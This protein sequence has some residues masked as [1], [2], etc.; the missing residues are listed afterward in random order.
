[1]G[2]AQKSLETN[3]RFSRP[4]ALRLDD[5]IRRIVSRIIGLFVLMFCA[6]SS[7]GS[8]VDVFVVDK[9][10]RPVADVAVYAMR[11]DEQYILPAPTAG[12]IM[13]QI[14]M[15]FVP[16]LLVVQTATSVEFPNNDTVAHHVYS[17]SYLNKFMLSMY[18]GKQH[19][20]VTFEHS[21]VVTLGCNI[22]DHMLGYIL[23][24]DST[25]FTKTD[26]NGK[27]LLSLDNP[28]DYEISIWSPR[29]R[30]GDELL[31]KTVVMPGNP[32]SEVKFQLAKKLNPP[33]GGQ[34]G[35]MTWSEY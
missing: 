17:F 22:H 6:T 24:V 5:K 32:G 19:P 7:F 8:D 14:D 26:E 3:M 12:A 1:M 25:A 2:D 33:H 4:S 16:H 9:D 28:E 11:L 34:S 15:Q 18:K 10:S 29:I 21:G 27:A 35:S 30:D 31:S 23:V 13:D 20:P